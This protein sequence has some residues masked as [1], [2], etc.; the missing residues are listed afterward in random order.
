MLN[1]EIL[2]SPS[3]EPVSFDEQSNTLT[4]LQVFSESSGSR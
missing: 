2:H 3:L 1:P 4:H